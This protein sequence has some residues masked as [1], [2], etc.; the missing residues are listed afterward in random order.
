MAF[1][2]L[3]L[4]NAYLLQTHEYV[5]F[6][7]Q[8]N[9]R[10]RQLRGTNALDKENTTVLYAPSMDHLVPVKLDAVATTPTLEATVDRANLIDLLDFD[11]DD[12]SGAEQWRE[13]LEDA[14]DFFDQ[15]VTVQKN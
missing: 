3:L 11:D 6:D 2:S 1:V 8:N 13:E 10:S 14:P 15:V 9:S 5:L 12:G 7:K 4:V